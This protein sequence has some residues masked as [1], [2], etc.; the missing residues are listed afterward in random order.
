MATVSGCFIKPMSMKNTFLHQ[1]RISKVSV[2]QQPTAKPDLVELPKI[3]HDEPNE[4]GPVTPPHLIG[5]RKSC[6]S[7]SSKASLTVSLLAHHH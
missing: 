5:Q 4:P 1:L 3:N 2:S 6:G 7:F